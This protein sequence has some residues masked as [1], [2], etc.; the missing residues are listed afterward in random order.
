MVAILSGAVIMDGALLL[1]GAN[2]SCPQ[3]QTRELLAIVDNGHLQHLK[4]FRS[5]RGQ[6]GNKPSPSSNL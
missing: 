1:I 4:V 5:A 3:P 6:V 2:E